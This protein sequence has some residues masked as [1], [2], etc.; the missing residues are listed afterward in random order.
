M[1][2]NWLIISYEDNNPVPIPTYGN[3][4]GPGYSGGLLL[5]GDEDFTSIYNNIP[6]TDDLDALFRE[7]DQSY[8][9]AQEW[10]Q[11]QL[12]LGPPNSTITNEY[13]TRQYNADIEL[14]LG[15]YDLSP[16]QLSSNDA[17]AC[18]AQRWPHP[19][20]PWV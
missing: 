18:P 16:S 17:R 15:I 11:Q 4:G 3:Y 7:H 14:I 20:P 1:S 9:L 2:I 13:L 5:T 19:I 8:N 12:E 6:A 10:Y